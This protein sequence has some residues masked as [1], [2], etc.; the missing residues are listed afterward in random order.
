MSVVPITSTGGFGNGS[1]ERGAV[2]TKI[3]LSSWKKKGERESEEYATQ[4]RGCG[5][6][7]TKR[8]MGK[9]REI[10]GA[11]AAPDMKY[12]ECKIGFHFKC[13]PPLIDLSPFYGI[14]HLSDDV[15]VARVVK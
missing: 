6:I 12:M 15:T 5:Y 8:Q 7:M 10:V 2:C 4:K 13:T 1:R 9:S 11:I 14:V 3:S